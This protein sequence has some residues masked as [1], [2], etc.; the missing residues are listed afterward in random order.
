MIRPDYILEEN[1]P[2]RLIRVDAS[3]RWAKLV[4]N[5]GGVLLLFET[6]AGW[7]NP[8]PAKTA[9]GILKSLRPNPPKLA[10]VRRID[11][12]RGGTYEVAADKVTIFD[13]QNIK[14]YPGLLSDYLLHESV[15]ATGHPTRLAR[16]TFAP[17]VDKH[18][19]WE[20]Q[21]ELL[22]RGPRSE[23]EIP[24]R[25]AEEVVACLATALASVRIGIQPPPPERSWFNRASSLPLDELRQSIAD[26]QSA[27]AFMLNEQPPPI[28]T[29]LV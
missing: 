21:K 23:E 4:H 11:P 29:G 6:W 12:E 7:N 9:M 5:T 2:L 25:V 14:K 3:P 13:S 10:M 22:M 18:L 1:G 20:E 17:Q 28:F 24:G 8:D 26:A 16:P 27:V 19:T 15:H